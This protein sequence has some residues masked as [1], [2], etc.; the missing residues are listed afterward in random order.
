MLSGIADFEPATRPSP[1]A[2]TRDSHD[3]PVTSA[4]RRPNPAR[5]SC[6]PCGMTPAGREWFRSLVIVALCFAFAAW[7]WTAGGAVFERPTFDEA[8]HSED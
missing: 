1:A 6:Y 3:G 7:L 5:L 8:A 4:C 2:Q